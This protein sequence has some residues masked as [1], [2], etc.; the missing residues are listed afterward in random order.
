MWKCRSM[1]MNTSESSALSKSDYCHYGFEF[2]GILTL[3]VTQSAFTCSNLTLETLEQGV[4]YVQ[5]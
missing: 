2:L 1:L 5:S 4:K 3:T